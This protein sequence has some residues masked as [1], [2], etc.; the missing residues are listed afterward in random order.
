MRHY[1]KQTK[2]QSEVVNMVKAIFI[3][4]SVCEVITITCNVINW[5]FKKEIEKML[6][7]GAEERMRLME[8]EAK[9]DKPVG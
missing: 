9:N 8:E 6:S 7:E 2:T 5:C 1:L 3:I 4:F